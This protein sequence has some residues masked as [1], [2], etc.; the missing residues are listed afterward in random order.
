MKI[1][2]CMRG[3]PIGSKAGGEGLEMGGMDKI[4]FV[5]YNR[6]RNE[7]IRKLVCFTRVFFALYLIYLY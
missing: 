4:R 5:W 2:F 1:L 7:R 6:K 3:V